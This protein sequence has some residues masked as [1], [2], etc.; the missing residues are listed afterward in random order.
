MTHGRGAF[1]QLAYTSASSTNAGNACQ[2]GGPVSGPAL[3]C[4]APQLGATTT[5]TLT[6]GVVPGTAELYVSA[7]PPAPIQ[8]STGCFVQIDPQVLVPVGAQPLSA[9]GG[10]SWTIPWPDLPIFAG[11]KLMTQSAVVSTGTL[12]LS[13]GR[14]LTL[15]Y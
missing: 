10:A 11:T 1:R 6:G 12:R 15:G 7:I 13:N 14:L 9:G 4:T 8:I 3:A 5:F 2:F